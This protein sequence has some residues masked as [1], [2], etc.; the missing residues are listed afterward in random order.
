[1]S[2]LIA[3]ATDLRNNIT[4]MGVNFLRVQINNYLQQHPTAHASVV[5]YLH[6][7]YNKLATPTADNLDRIINNFQDAAQISDSGT[8]IPALPQDDDFA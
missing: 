2:D 4:P 1:M 6:D 8:F 7:A 5:A 3:S